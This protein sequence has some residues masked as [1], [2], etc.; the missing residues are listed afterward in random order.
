MHLL[1]SAGCVVGAAGVSG[2]AASLADKRH[3]KYH[4]GECEKHWLVV[5]GA[6]T[7]QQS[8][9]KCNEFRVECGHDE[10]PL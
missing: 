9:G 4:S 10:F 3:H 2:V 1:L 6:K 5:G 7:K 8:K